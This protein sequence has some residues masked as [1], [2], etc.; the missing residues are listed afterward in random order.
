MTTGPVGPISQK[1][2]GHPETTAAL[3]TLT[4]LLSGARYVD[5]SPTIS[6]GMPRWP[7]HPAVD[8]D[9]AITHE[10]DGY[11][12]QTLTLG[13][14]T[15]AHVDAPAH[16]HGNMMDH[17]VEAIP[18]NK[19]IAPTKTFDLRAYGLKPGQLATAQMLASLDRW[20]TPLQAGE[21][22]LLNFGWYERFW[23]LD[24][25]CRWYSEN[26]PGLSEDACEWL[27]DRGILAAG[28]D[29]VAFDIALVNGEATH[30]APAHQKYLLP[31]DINIIECLANLDKMPEHGYF[32]ALPLKIKGG[33]G[34][35][36]R[37]I[38]LDLGPRARVEPWL[39]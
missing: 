14:H 36:L 7:T 31:Q 35:P 6:I 20:S 24:P 21:I 27:A 28:S 30:G 34:S 11:F 32:I 37:P 2:D 22:A 4:R 39:R 15:G 17:T 19:L 38:G 23:D 29:T 13:E 1:P 18:V 5:L 33:S 10:R 3:Q 9:Q 25:H 16:I 8:I 12:C 26:T